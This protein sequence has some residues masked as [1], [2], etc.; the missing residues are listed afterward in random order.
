MKQILVDSLDALKGLR[1]L[2]VLV[3]A[4]D[5]PEGD[6]TL[7]VPDPIYL[8][9]VNEIG[10]QS[11]AWFL[12]PDYVGNVSSKDLLVQLITANDLKE[13]EPMITEHNLGVVTTSCIVGDVQIGFA[14]GA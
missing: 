12:P 5:K 13:L 10:T 8:N 11:G 4:R 6:Q 1:L 9:G 7:P 14:A 2:R 3:K